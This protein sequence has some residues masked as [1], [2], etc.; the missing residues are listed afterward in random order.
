MRVYF[1]NEGLCAQDL[2]I[3]VVDLGGIAANTS[4]TVEG[5]VVCVRFV[6]LAL[7]APCGPDINTSIDQL[8]IR[9]KLK[10]HHDRLSMRL[11][12]SRFTT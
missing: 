4:Q 1:L 7:L 6:R 2:D 9:L 10:W 5:L 3:I 11:I 12:I 8:L